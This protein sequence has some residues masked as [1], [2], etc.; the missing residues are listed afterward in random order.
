M[1]SV[2][3]PCDN[4]FDLLATSMLAYRSFHIGLTVRQPNTEFIVITRNPVATIPP[5]ITQVI[6]Y[7]FSGRI[8]NPAKALNIGVRNA[9]NPNIV[10]TCPEVMPL[11]PV[12]YQF[13]KLVGQNVLAQVFEDGTP[14]VSSTFRAELPGLYFLAM[15]NLDAIKKINGWD[16]AFMQG[17]AWEDTD[18]GERLKRAGISYRIEDSIQARHQH[19]D[20]FWDPVT[21]RINRQIFESNNTWGLVRPKKGLVEEQ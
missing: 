11:T 10:I 9:R 13:E 15:Y 6:P 21:T 17:S 18:F 7:E 2:I 16:E 4:R 20:R 3:I 8:C 1:F 14:L 19:H 12:L 5:G